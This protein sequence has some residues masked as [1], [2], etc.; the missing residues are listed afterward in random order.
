MND[1]HA[2]GVCE[3]KR[4]IAISP[5]L[6]YKMT[7]AV[8]GG[9]WEYDDDIP[10]LIKTTKMTTKKIEYP[11]QNPNTKPKPKPR[12]GEPP[13]RTLTQSA[14][15]PNPVTLTLTLTQ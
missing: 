11:N 2:S 5:T 4:S 6:V 13:P 15:N 12:P 8:L 3:A 7:F 14:S 9:S 1:L 10:R